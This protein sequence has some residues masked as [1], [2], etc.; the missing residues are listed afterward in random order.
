MDS[1]GRYSA[2]IYRLT[3]SIFNNRLKELEIGSGQYDFFLVI[4]R[5]EGINQ[6]DLGDSLYVEKS[7]AA[8]AVKVLVDK[9]YVEKKR[10]QKDKRYYSLYLTDKG[11]KASA[12]VD[13]V[14]SEILSIFSKN[15]SDSTIDEAISVLKKVIINLQE[16]KSIFTRD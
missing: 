14:F 5:N 8:K 9:G 7:T 10:N 4:A 11:R 16:E 2:A 6:K 15:I 1:I 12:D 3:Q 13:A